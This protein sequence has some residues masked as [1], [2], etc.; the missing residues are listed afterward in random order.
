LFDVH[1]DVDLRLACEAEAAAEAALLVAEGHDAERDVD[2]LGGLDP[3]EH[4][5]DA[6]VPPA[7]GNGIEMRARPHTRIAACA[8]QVPCRVDLHLEPCLAHPFGGERVRL[9]LLGRV[10]DAIADRVDPLDPLED[11]HCY[12]RRN[13]RATSPGPRGCVLRHSS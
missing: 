4:A 2:S 10:A 3:R 9:V 13:K 11:P 7:V 1:L 12:D 8:D 5:E 6:V